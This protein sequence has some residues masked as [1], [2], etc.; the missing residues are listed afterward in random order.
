ML[1]KFVGQDIPGTNHRMVPTKEHQK[2]LIDAVPGYLREIVSKQ[3][4]EILTAPDALNHISNTVPGFWPLVQEKA[5]ITSIQRETADTSTVTLRPSQGRLRFQAGQFIQHGVVRDF[6]IYFLTYLPSGTNRSHPESRQFAVTAILNTTL[7]PGTNSSESEA[8]SR[9]FSDWSGPKSV[10]ERLPACNPSGSTQTQVPAFAAD[11]SSTKNTPPAV[12]D[13]S[14]YGQRSSV[15]PSPSP[16]T[17]ICMSVT[18]SPAG[19][20]TA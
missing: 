7:V 4:A 10:A 16:S 6:I 12:V 3:A 11:P 8:L 17:R 14:R 15:H 18:C 2:V 19:L 5:R 1:R 13:E 20:A 9:I